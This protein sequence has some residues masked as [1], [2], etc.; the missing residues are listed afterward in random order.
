M[1]KKSKQKINLGPF[2]LPL[3]AF[4]SIV[5]FVGFVAGYTA[6]EFQEGEEAG[7]IPQNVRVC[8]SPDGRCENLIVRTINTAKNSIY[9]RAYSFTAQPIADALIASHKRGVKVNVLVDKSQLEE[10]YTKIH[11]LINN[12]ISVRIEHAKGIAHNKVIIIDEKVI[13]TGS[14]NFSNSANVRNAENLL[15]I[16]SPALAKLYL[17]DWQQGR[18][19]SKKP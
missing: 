16:P 10:R 14:Y 1:P 15:V 7:P 13:L 11:Q 19:D 4:T 18:L 9:L 2:R 12:G 6:L 5:L 8:F 3:P 17:D